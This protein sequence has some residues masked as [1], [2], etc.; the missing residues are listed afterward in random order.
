[1]HDT[2][3][4]AMF[5]EML[6]F[7]AVSITQAQQAINDLNVFPVPDGNIRPHRSGKEKSADGDNSVSGSVQSIL[8][9]K[10]AKPRPMPKLRLFIL[11][12]IL[13]GLYRR[14]SF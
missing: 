10:Q 13:N 3:N 7:G 8:C 12:L 1:M 4:G 2:I 6:L 5:K 9:R 11:F 14:T